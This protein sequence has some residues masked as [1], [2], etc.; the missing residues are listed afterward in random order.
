MILDAARWI[1]SNLFLFVSFSR[2]SQIAAAYR[3]LGNVY[4]AN[5]KSHQTIVVHMNWILITGKWKVI[6]KHIEFEGVIPNESYNLV[7]T[8]SIILYN[9]SKRNF[10]SFRK[11]AGIPLLY[12]SM[13]RWA[14][15]TGHSFKNVS[16]MDTVA[17][18]GLHYC[19]VHHETQQCGTMMPG[20]LKRFWN[21]VASQ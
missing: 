11:H 13:H 16:K 10:S 3:K 9:W 5:I 14:T 7:S 20:F 1:R 2:P 4:I 19:S 8:A 15:E 12:S 18:H 21:C 17:S 6:S